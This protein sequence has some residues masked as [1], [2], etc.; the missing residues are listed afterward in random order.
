MRTNPLPVCQFA[1][2]YLNNILQ[3]SLNAFLLSPPYQ[4]PMPFL[5]L[6][7]FCF[8]KLF[9][10]HPPTLLLHPSLPLLLK[11]TL[12]LFLPSGP[13]HSQPVPP[14]FPLFLTTPTLLFSILS[15]SLIFSLSPCE[16][17]IRTFQILSGGGIF[18]CIMERWKNVWGF[19]RAFSWWKI[20]SL[21]SPLFAAF[22]KAKVQHYQRKGLQSLS[23]VN[24]ADL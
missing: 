2:L 3:V 8:H 5:P 9:F 7:K 15:F 21:A 12:S 16:C 24:I 20:A 14:I 22:L 23:Q 10:L 19:K 1:E 11:M 13:L 6:E 18:I 4:P 17:C